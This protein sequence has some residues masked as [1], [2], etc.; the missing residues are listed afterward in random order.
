MCA[1][2]WFRV[3]GRPEK[4]LLVSA[5]RRVLYG[6]GPQFFCYLIDLIGRIN[7]Y[8]QRTDFQRNFQHSTPQVFFGM[9]L[10]KFERRNYGGKWSISI[11]YQN[12]HSHKEGL[13]D[14]LIPEYLWNEKNNTFAWF[15]SLYNSFK[16]I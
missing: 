8:F 6:P 7:S 13:I 16:Q 1:F 2:L 15:R 10:R 3:T 14:F 11:K 4:Y 5:W 12:L 9:V